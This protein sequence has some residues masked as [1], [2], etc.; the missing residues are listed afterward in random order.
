MNRKANNKMIE[1]NE[2]VF[3]GLTDSRLYKWLA[4]FSVNQYIRRIGYS[5][6]GCVV[7]K[8]DQEDES[9]PVERVIESFFDLTG[10]EVFKNEMNFRNGLFSRIKQVQTR[11]LL[12]RMR[13]LR[14]YLQEHF[15]DRKIIVIGLVCT[16]ETQ[17][18]FHEK[19]EKELWLADNIDEY[20]DGVVALVPYVS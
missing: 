9:Y 16:N 7:M 10:Y 18:R 20:T 17:I 12:L 5:Q 6:S 4:S 1:I 8:S 15:P 19:K 13:I 3:R 11:M 2:V 14:D